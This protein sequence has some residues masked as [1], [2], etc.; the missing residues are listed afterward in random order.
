M[1]RA[2]RGGGRVKDWG[3]I[4]LLLILA[5]RSSA[6]RRSGPGRRGGPWPPGTDNLGTMPVPPS[7]H[8]EPA[9][10]PLK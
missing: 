9:L 2:V 1:G 4:V 3:V 10:P 7:S 6:P 5:S 8:P